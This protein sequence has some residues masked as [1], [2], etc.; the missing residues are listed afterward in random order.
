MK[1]THF[2]YA[3]LAL[4]FSLALSGYCRDRPAPHP[5][6]YGFSF[7]IDAKSLPKG[8][9]LREVRSETSIRYFMK[10]TSLV[11]LIINERFQNN[12][13]V[14]GAKLVSGEVLNYFPNGV[15]MA[16]KQHLK[17]WQSPFGKIPET[18]LYI[19]EPKKIYEGRKAGLTR[20]LPP[21]EKLSIAANLNGKPY[22]ISGTIH[23]HLNKAYDPF[24]R[25]KIPK[26]KTLGR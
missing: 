21:V 20:K 25:I 24:H 26:P 22:E 6:R 3:L 14:S 4:M 18:L 2:H 23:F 5:S 13:L 19:K 12:R 10:N 15:P 9:T 16:G 7:V 17:G 11:P 8:V 1:R